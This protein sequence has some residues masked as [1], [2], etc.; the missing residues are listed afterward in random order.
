[1]NINLTPA[2]YH[3]L[4]ILVLSLQTPKSQASATD[5]TVEVN[6]TKVVFSAAEVK[7]KLS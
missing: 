1:M 6:A 4:E 2:Q 5:I 7:F 3:E